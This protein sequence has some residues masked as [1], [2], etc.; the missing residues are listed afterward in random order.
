MNWIRCASVADEKSVISLIDPMTSAHRL[1]VPSASFPVPARAGLRIEPLV[2]DPL[3]RDG[4][5][6]ECLGN[7]CGPPLELTSDPKRGVNAR[8]S[9][10]H[11]ISPAWACRGRVSLRLER[12]VNRLDAAIE[13]TFVG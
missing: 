4:L 1:A 11:C 2:G 9:T 3:N 13:R 5:T 7:P 8:F 10:R 6:A 12:N